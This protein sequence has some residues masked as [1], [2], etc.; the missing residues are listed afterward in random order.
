MSFKNENLFQLLGETDDELLDEAYRIDSADKLKGLKHGKHSRNALGNGFSLK[1]PKQIIAAAACLIL[2]TVSVL[3]VMPMINSNMNHGHAGELSQ[4]E[5]TNSPAAPSTENDFPAQPNDHNKPQVI[6]PDWNTLDYPVVTL[7]EGK[8]HIDG[9]DMLNYY[10]A[11]RGIYEAKNSGIRGMK[12][13]GRSKPTMLSES[14][15]SGVS[16]AFDDG[17]SAVFDDDVSA[18]FD[19][20]VSAAFG[21]EVSAVLD[22]EVSAPSTDF[23]P[24]PPSEPSIYY[25]KIGPHDRLG[26]S[27]LLF[28]QIKI[29]DESGF[30]AQKMGTGTI[31]VVISREFFG[32]DE[33]I[34]F[35]NGDKY[36][37]CLT[38]S[39]SIEYKD[40]RPIRYTFRFSTHK[41]I[42]GFYVVKNF[43]QPNYEFE[44]CVSIDQAISF[45]CNSF[46]NGINPDGVLPI[47]SKT[48]AINNCTEK[49]T[50]AELE[51]Y[52]NF[53]D[54]TLHAIFSQRK[55]PKMSLSLV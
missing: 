49:F 6:Q 10:S 55:R 31:D 1:I 34:T 52:F 30:L 38:N 35:K 44:V 24:D 5:N 3:T 21:D 23:K 32:D 40:S 9:I 20:E 29:T 48:I 16:A 2:C 47:V 51:N 45:K 19:D 17:V 8:L 54:S 4:V 36:F 11:V 42:E 50:I 39:Y 7:P 15:D 18:V 12:A 53:L 46:H 41:F 26:P 25:Y 43:K 27:Q 14:M 28:F 33:L 13:T 37:S 22:D